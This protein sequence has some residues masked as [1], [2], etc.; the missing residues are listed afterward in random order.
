MRSI[1]KSRVKMK[2][3]C[4]E[5]RNEDCEENKKTGQ[6]FGVDNIQLLIF[7]CGS[8]NEECSDVGAVFVIRRIIDGQK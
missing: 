2:V 1:W 4:S 7:T 3:H 8:A 5:G 6:Q